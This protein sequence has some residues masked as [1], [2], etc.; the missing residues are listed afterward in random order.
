MD[1]VPLQNAQEW[2][3]YPWNLLHLHF[4]FD[5]DF[6]INIHLESA[7]RIEIQWRF[8]NVEQVLNRRLV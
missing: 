2:F 5:A 4:Y 6:V 8:P 3:R 1:Q 7:V